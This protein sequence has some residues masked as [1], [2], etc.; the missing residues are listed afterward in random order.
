M[1]K[2]SL[3]YIN[4]L[5]ERYPI[6]NICYQQIINST[7]IIASA[8]SNGNKLLICG[9]GGSAADSIH[10]VAELMKGFVLPRHIQEQLIVK[11][12]KI[13]NSKERHPYDKLQG[14]LPAISLM[15]E[16]ALSS[17]FSNDQDYNLCI[18]QQVLGYGKENDVLLA[19][20]T[21]GNSLN[22]VYAAQI[23]KALNINVIGLTGNNGGELRKFCDCTIIVPENI[24][25]KIQELHL[26]IYHTICLALENEF[27]GSN[28]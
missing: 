20:S 5:I 15:S 11:I 27:F 4:L 17:A 19:I 22:V 23:A 9:N 25:Y 7:T 12:Q 26:P 21:S 2:S 18:A 3:E 14:T 16:I 28:T 10:I 1:K 24:T 8:F 6:L 13:T